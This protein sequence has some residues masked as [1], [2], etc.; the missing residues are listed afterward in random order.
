MAD[1]YGDDDFEDYDDEFED[2]AEEEAPTAADAQ[3]VIAEADSERARG[4]RRQGRRA[5]AARKCRR[6]P[7]PRRRRSSRRRSF[8]SSHRRRRRSASCRSSRARGSSRRMR[9]RA[10]LSEV[11]AVL[12][13]APPLSEYELH[14]R[15]QGRATKMKLTQ[16][17]EDNVD[18][19]VQTEEIDQ[20]SHTCQVP[21]DMGGP[22]RRDAGGGGGDTSLLAAN[23]ARLNR[24]LRGAGGVMEALC[25]ENLL[26]AAAGGGG[27]AAARG[28]RRAAGGGA[29]GA[30][31]TASS[32]PFASRT[33]AFALGE[34]LGPRPL[35]DVCFFPDGA[36]MLAAYGTPFA[37]PREPRKTPAPL[38]RLWSGG[39]LC[40]WR[41]DHPAAP[42]HL[43]R[44]VGLPACCLVCAAKPHLAFAGTSEG[45]V[46]VTRRHRR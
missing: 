16:T 39:V 7:S 35:A 36:S 43:L 29:A 31:T 30:A 28:R 12:Y 32:L 18:A 33:T 3:K 8:T 9:A 40:V 20:E 11:D 37:P 15:Q 25:A 45:S 27:A 10:Q 2:D 17:G 21:D 13:D 46:Q 1:E 34:P 23:V 14:L 19:G 44:C 22:S 26:R 38:R 41:V 4:W 6:P 24:F 5:S 42:W